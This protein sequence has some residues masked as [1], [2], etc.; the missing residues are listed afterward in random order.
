MVQ[1]STERRLGP[2]ARHPLQLVAALI[3]LLY[4]AIG[5]AGF[6]VTGA[7]DFARES[8]A[9]LLWFGVNPLLNLVHIAVGLAGLVLCVDPARA[10]A[11]GWVLF[12]LFGAAFVFGLLA[13][14]RPSINILSLDMADN[15]MHVA[16]AIL[17]LAMALWPSGA[18]E[19]S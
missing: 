9:Q 16:T 1:V 17:G 8:S 10:R 13:V 19:M 15:I 6:F 7:A 5:V 2:I 14:G 3:G 18:T 4:L 12:G 11:Y